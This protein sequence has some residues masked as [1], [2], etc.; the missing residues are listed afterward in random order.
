MPTFTTPEPITVS[1]ELALGDAQITATD[2]SDTVV[3]VRPSDAD[4]EADVRAAELTRVE[5][6]DG[7]L[8]IRAPKQRSFGLFGKVGSIDVVVA[9]P[10]GSHLHGDA[11]VAAFRG[12]GRL[13]ECRIRTS[14]GD[15]QLDQTGALDLNTAGGAIGVTRVAGH[16]E[17]RTGTG[18]VRLQEIDGSAVIKNSNGDSWVGTI[19]GDLKV[20]AANGDIVVDRSQARLTAATANGDVRIGEAVRGWV[21]IKTSCGELQVGIR[22]GTAALLDVHTQYGTVHNGL[23]ACDPPAQEDGSTVEIRARTSYGDIVLHRS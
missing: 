16:A 17:V 9:A 7:R 10:T 2:R 18:R 8:L 19:T 22:A 23:E 1:I 5:Y 6:A 4:A 12:T 11:S 15:I 3:E 21:S 13:G 20:N 14:T